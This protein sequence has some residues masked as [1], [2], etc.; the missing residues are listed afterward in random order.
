VTPSTKVLT[1]KLL[2]FHRWIF[3]S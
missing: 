3:F 2:H 1:S